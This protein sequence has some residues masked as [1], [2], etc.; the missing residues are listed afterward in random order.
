MTRKSKINFTSVL[1]YHVKKVQIKDQSS[2]LED[3]PSSAQQDLLI[4]RM[5]K[6]K[7]KKGE[8]KLTT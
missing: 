4:M 6:L 5:R 1:P 7:I 8:K 3:L 2:V